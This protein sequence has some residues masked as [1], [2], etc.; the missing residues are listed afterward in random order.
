M[1]NTF[2]KDDG[3]NQEILKA[4]K[5]LFSKYGLK[6][7]TMEDVARHVGK[8]KSTLYYYYPGKNE[9]FEAV[10][11]EEFN[12][13]V[14]KIR[15]AV[16]QENT[17]KAKLQAYLTSRLKLRE[18]YNNLSKV[19]SDEI[20]DH[21][22]EIFRLKNEFTEVHIDFIKEIVKSGVQ[23]GD[24]KPMTDDEISFF[25]NWIN[26][27]FVGLETPTQS[28]LCI[29]ESHESC[30]KLVDLIIGGINA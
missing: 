3:F 12:N 24:F 19:I 8:G 23:L 4:A 17:S 29:I 16:N 20:F 25:A 5:L 10:V 6:K 27:A 7:T 13:A 15:L 14:K 26:A 1:A 9:L 21:L 18:E 11:K 22:R 28:S 30:S 2:S